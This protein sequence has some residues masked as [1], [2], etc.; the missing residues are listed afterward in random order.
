MRYF[1][2]TVIFAGAYGIR[3]AGK[4]KKAYDQRQL[5]SAQG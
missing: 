5:L 3:L 1:D 4:Q 2:V